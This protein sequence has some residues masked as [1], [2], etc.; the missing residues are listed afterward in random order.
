[1]DIGGATEAGSKNKL[2][3]QRLKLRLRGGVVVKLSR[4]GSRVS[5]GLVGLLIGLALG[6]A[7]IMR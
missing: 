7:T 6:I 4:V 2:L 3:T 1:M 5:V